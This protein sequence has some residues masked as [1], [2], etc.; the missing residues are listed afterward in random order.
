MTISYKMEELYP[1]LE[2][3][4]RK[5]TSNES[6]S[7]SYETARQLMS[8]ILYCMEESD[9][10]KGTELTESKGNVKR[11]FKIGLEKKKEKI[12]LAKKIFQDLEG[13]FES[14]GNHCYQDTV[15]KGMPGFFYKYDVEFDAT[16]T[17][18]TL[19]YPLLMPIEGLE[20]INLIY[21][22][23]QSVRIENAFLRY[24]GTSDV[25]E[26]LKDYHVNYRELVI[27]ICEIVLYKAIGCSLAGKPV[28]SLHLTGEDVKWVTEKIKSS[29]EYELKD[30]LLAAWQQILKETKPQDI[31][32]KDAYKQYF[33]N[34]SD[35]MVSD[36]IS[37]KKNNKLDMLFPVR[38]PKKEIVNHFEDGECMEDEKLRK[39][40]EEMQE[41]RLLSDKII[42]LKENVKSLGDLREILQE[43]F[44]EDEFNS[45]FCLLSKE[46]LQY[47][48]KNIKE[49]VAFGENLYEW[50]KAFLQ[51]CQ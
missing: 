45:V 21:R 23:L 10:L 32:L 11:A 50:E 36:F 9:V 13:N 51:Y 49:K 16:N 18:L 6:S 3:R 39:L 33:A 43:C 40:I 31:A 41:C 47:I 19:D 29:Q 26:V 4:I 44:W 14:Y 27:N 5:F 46:E 17:I 15:I 24:F 34:A 7:V 37:Y 1:L 38:K 8:S 2:D 12:S 25:I 42:L 48:G 22:Y 35:K 30:M 20:G 28:G